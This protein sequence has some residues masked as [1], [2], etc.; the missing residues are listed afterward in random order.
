MPRPAP[1]VA[2]ATTRHAA[3]QRIR[4]PVSSSH[5]GHTRE[6]DTV[7]ALYRRRNRHRSCRRPV[8]QTRSPAPAGT[9]RGER[10]GGHRT[11]RRL[12]RSN[13]NS[14]PTAN[15]P[16]T[17]TGAA[18]VQRATAG[19]GQ[20]AAHHADHLGRTRRENCR[21]RGPRRRTRAAACW[22]ST[23]TRAST[24]GSGRW[25]AGS[26]ASATRRWRSTCSR[27]RAARRSSPTRRRPPRRWARSRPKSSS[28]TSSPASAS[29]SAACRTRSSPSSGSA[30]AAG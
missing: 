13:Q 9:A 29:C 22:S 16:V 27:R 20:R 24:T 2:P 19:I 12:Q 25:R 5:T 1:R 7:T 17:S 15:A 26:P 23:R 10:R 18:T 21:R 30:W 28:P 11:D 6:C 3:A 4:H 8:V 14:K